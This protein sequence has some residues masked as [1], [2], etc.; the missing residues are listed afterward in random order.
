M[1]YSQDPF[2]DLEA[3]R[4]RRE[5]QKENT[6]RLAKCYAFWTTTGVGEM[7]IDTAFRF[8]VSFIEPPSFSYGTVLDENDDLVTGFYPRVSAGVYDWVREVPPGNADGD[9]S[10]LPYYI[11]AYVYF[12]V[13][14]IGGGRAFQYS[15]PQYNLHHHLSW[16]GQAIK[17]LPA[18][19]LDL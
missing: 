4:S 19:L 17:D 16:E 6:S 2:G 9:D 8:N 3:A 1:F 12:V 5:A 13:D 14:T 15:Q 10:L 11:G 7:R 18:H